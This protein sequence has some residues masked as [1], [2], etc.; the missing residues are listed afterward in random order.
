[1]NIGFSVINGNK[2]EDK[3][4]VDKNAKQELYKNAFVNVMIKET[5]TLLQE[6]D[7]LKQIVY[8]GVKY[9]NCIDTHRTVIMRE[10][11]QNEF[12]LIGI[13]KEIMKLLTLDELIN[14]FPIPKEFDGEKYCT[15]DY[16][17]AVEEFKQYNYNDPLCD[18][19][20]NILWDCM[21]YD[22]RNFQL[23]LFNVMDGIRRFNGEPGVMEEFLTDQGVEMYKINESNGKKYI[24]SSITGKT[25]PLKETKK[26]TRYLKVIS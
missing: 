7:R 11:V 5:E 15:K 1:M 22:L 23:C 20:E 21:N 12:T 16:F 6:R 18:N 25:V 9:I 14:V 8:Y 3:I 19:L 10:Q 13:I 17:Y 4:S 2:T 26:K 24:Q